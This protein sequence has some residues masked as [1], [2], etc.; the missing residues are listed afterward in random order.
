MSNSY[1]Y[2]LIS[3]SLM[4]YRLSP[5]DAL[6]SDRGTVMLVIL[7]AVLSTSLY[8]LISGLAPT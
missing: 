4:S 6:T 1:N 5:L 8:L 7:L 3:I 2:R